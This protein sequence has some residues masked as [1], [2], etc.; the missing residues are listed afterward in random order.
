MRIGIYGG[1][2]DPVH[3]GHWEAARAAADQF[4]LDRVLFVPAGHP[5]HRRNSPVAE[6]KH[7]LRMVEL[8][9][10]QDPRLM[11]SPLEAPGHGAETHYSIDT[12][13]HLRSQL[14]P[15]DQLFF[16]IGADAFAEITSWRR[17]RELADLVE[18]IVVSRPG[19]EADESLN[20][21]LVKTHWLRSVNVPI[22]STEIRQGLNRGESV[23]AWLAPAVDAYIRE[24]ELYRDGVLQAR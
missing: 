17:W 19:E 5:P 15:D 20:P 1:T 6:Y 4:S 24:H 2:F 10:A 8:V 21:E 9:C 3:L 12:V 18:F 22:S 11:S 23:D 7:R 16:I 13:Q 14:K